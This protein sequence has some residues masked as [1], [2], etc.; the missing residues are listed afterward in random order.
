M[1]TLFE[2][3]KAIK[4]LDTPEDVI[5]EACRQVLNQDQDKSSLSHHELAKDI[6]LTYYKK[7]KLAD[8]MIAAAI[9]TG[10]I[11]GVISKAGE[12]KA[13]LD[14]LY[15]FIKDEFVEAISTRLLEKFRGDPEAALNDLLRRARALNKPRE[16]GEE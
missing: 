16:L 5:K 14:G 6:S 13:L 10:H 3:T 1:L 4:S 9:I 7:V 11:A 2:T 8:L 12:E 15:G